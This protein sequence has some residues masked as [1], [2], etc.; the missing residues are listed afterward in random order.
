MLAGFAWS[1]AAAA[2]LYSLHSLRRTIGSCI[3]THT[4]THA[5]MLQSERQA[6]TQNYNQIL[7]KPNKKS[8]KGCLEMVS[9]TIHQNLNT[10]TKFSAVERP[11]ENCTQP[12][13]TL[14]F[15]SKCFISIYHHL[16]TIVLRLV[17]FLLLCMLFSFYSSV[18]YFYL[19]VYLVRLIFSITRHYCFLSTPKHPKTKPLRLL[20]CRSFP[21]NLIH[22]TAFLS[23]VL[24]LADINDDFTHYLHVQNT[25]VSDSNYWLAYKQHTSGKACT[26]NESRLKS[27]LSQT[28]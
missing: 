16:L 28:R 25:V 5:R 4:H 3:H 11:V 18:L 19:V 27:L 26:P 15:F 8:P 21:R 6:N 20:S 12:K 9:T 10:D 13:W 23:V 1:V 17:C 2:H 22:W 7:V 24:S 14:P